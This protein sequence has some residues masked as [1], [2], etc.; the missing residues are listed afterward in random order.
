[1]PDKDATKAAF[2]MQGKVAQIRLFFKSEPGHDHTWIQ[3]DVTI[4]AKAGGKRPARNV[5]SGP[6]K[7]GSRTA[8]CP[9]CRDAPQCLR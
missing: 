3:T 5:N 1:M 4:S 8:R 7:H 9:V 2:T 6:N